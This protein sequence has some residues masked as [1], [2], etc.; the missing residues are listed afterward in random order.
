[1]EGR[2]RGGWGSEGSVRADR[3]HLRDRHRI[4]IGGLDRF[5]LQ[6]RLMALAEGQRAILQPGVL[7]VEHPQGR[8]AAAAGI[9]AW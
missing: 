2:E 9:I 1:V 3:P 8:R 4:G 6:R 5:R 7:A